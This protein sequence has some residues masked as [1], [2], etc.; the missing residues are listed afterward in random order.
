MFIPLG[1]KTK[2][3]SVWPITQA[4]KVLCESVDTYCFDKQLHKKDLSNI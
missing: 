3:F 1:L 2:L 4:Q